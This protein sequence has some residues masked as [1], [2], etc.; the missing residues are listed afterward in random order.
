MLGIERVTG[1]NYGGISKIWLAYQRDVDAYLDFE[2]ERENL[3]ISQAHFD[4][5]F[6]QVIFKKRTA[7]YDFDQSGENYSNEVEATFL[8]SR[9][10]LSDHLKLA[11]NSKLCLVM[12]TLNG[13][14]LILPKCTES[15]ATRFGKDPMN[16][17]S[18]TIKWVS[19]LGY[20]APLISII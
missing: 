12:K 9:T 19:E 5:I 8:K 14:W 20:D 6:D 4:M 18:C 16:A 7:N 15:S 17:N 3:S 13:D 1:D 2:Y 11:Q 10:E